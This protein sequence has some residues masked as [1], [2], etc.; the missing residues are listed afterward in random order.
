MP[1]G[2]KVIPYLRTENLKKHTLSRGTYLYSPYMGVPPPPPPPPGKPTSKSVSQ[3]VSQSVSLHLIIHLII[4]FQTLYFNHSRTDK[5]IFDEFMKDAMEWKKKS[6][7]KANKSNEGGSKNSP[8]KSSE[9]KAPVSDTSAEEKKNDKSQFGANHKHKVAQKAASCSDNSNAGPRELNRKASSPTLSANSGPAPPVLRS[10]RPSPPTQQATDASNNNNL[11]CDIKEVKSEKNCLSPEASPPSS[12]RPSECVLGQEPGNQG[13]VKSKSSRRKRNRRK[14]KASKCPKW[15]N[16]FGT[17]FNDDRDSLS[18]ESESHPCKKTPEKVSEVI[19]GPGTCKN[20]DQ[21][22]GKE[23]DTKNGD[24]I[25]PKNVKESSKNKKG[26]KSHCS[27]PDETVLKRTKPY[28]AAR[29]E[30]LE[31]DR[32]VESNGYRT[33]PELGTSPSDVSTCDESRP[34]PAVEP[35]SSDNKV[36]TV[37]AANPEALALS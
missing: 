13:E 7:Q 37:S 19:D 35:S 33:S 9:H 15:L 4:C 23:K 31:D 34:I 5:E 1:K 16:P 27:L 17:K 32:G 26:S 24:A 21:G 25:V 6:L 14:K 30:E 29:F 36:G 10:S 22:D 20:L 12:E 28:V 11:K 2:T 18:S 3:S 8:K